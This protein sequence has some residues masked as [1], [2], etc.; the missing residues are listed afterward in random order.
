MMIPGL[1]TCNP[2]EDGHRSHVTMWLCD[3]QSSRGLQY[4]MQLYIAPEGYDVFFIRKCL[5]DERPIQE[6]A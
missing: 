3:L 5:R 1:L 4:I 2:E 6:I